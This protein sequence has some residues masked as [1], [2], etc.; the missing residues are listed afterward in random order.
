MSFNDEY[1]SI[2]VAM[3]VI[4][5][6]TDIICD[7]AKIIDL[8]R[9]RKIDIYTWYEGHIMHI[10][11][12]N[13][14]E[15][16]VTAVSYN[17]IF[18]KVDH[19]DDVYKIINDDTKSTEIK[20]WIS[21]KDTITN[22]LS[23]FLFINEKQI[24]QRLIDSLRVKPLSFIELEEEFGIST[25]EKI[26]KRSDLRV[27]KSNI[28]NVIN[29]YKLEKEN[30]VISSSIEESGL[31]ALLDE[32]HPYYAPDLAIGVKMWLENYKNADPHKKSPH[33]PTFDSF[34]NK[35]AIK[36]NGESNKRLREVTSPFSSWSTHRKD[37]QAEA[38]NES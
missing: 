4:S 27:K 19:S 37:K 20:G 21:E 11:F 23:G 14:P 18:F 7:E 32:S 25:T 2:D 38:K 8:Y 34:L 9:Q 3:Q 17:N 26:L 35:R 16:V 28:S 15:Y 24:T 6:N 36:M 1:Y 31:L 29:D 10:I 5:S 12:D 30:P 13:F 33:K 22:F